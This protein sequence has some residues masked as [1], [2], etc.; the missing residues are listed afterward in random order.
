[1]K[2]NQDDK[3]LLFL[4]KRKVAN[5]SNIHG[6]NGEGDNTG[7]SNTGGETTFSMLPAP[8]TYEYVCLQNSKVYELRVKVT[9]SVILNPTN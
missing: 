9:G 5:L 1:M 8:E 7:D 2:K 6:G 4:K 3:N